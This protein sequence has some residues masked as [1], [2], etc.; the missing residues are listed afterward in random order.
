MVGNRILQKLYEMS[1]SYLCTLL[2]QTLNLALSQRN[3]QVHI[4]HL[5]VPFSSHTLFS[6]VSVLHISLTHQR[7]FGCAGF[8]VPDS[9]WCANGFV[10]G[11][12]LYLSLGKGTSAV[13]QIVEVVSDVLHP[14]PLLHFCKWDNLVPIH[15]SLALL[16]LNWDLPGLDTGVQLLLQV[17]WDLLQLW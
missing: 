2:H 10:P 7:M 11:L 15:I 5:V 8:V 12:A 14:N 4:F 9:F 16:Q 3:S 17:A 1:I 6:G 13:H